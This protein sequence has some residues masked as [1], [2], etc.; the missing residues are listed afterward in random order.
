VGDAGGQTLRE[1]TLKFRLEPMERK[2]PDDTLPTLQRFMAQ[3]GIQ[4]CACTRTPE[5]YD[6]M[7]L[8][9]LLY[10]RPTVSLV[11]QL[12]L[13]TT[14]PCR[15]FHSLYAAGHHELVLAL[16]IH[17]WTTLSSPQSLCSQVLTLAELYMWSG[18]LGTLA[19]MQELEENR[20]LLDQDPEAYCLARQHRVAARGLEFLQAL[21]AAVVDVCS[22]CS[23]DILL[24]TLVYRLPCGHLFHADAT[25]CLGDASITT[26]LHMSTL[27]P[28]CKQIVH[29]VPPVG[30][31]SD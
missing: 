8:T 17:V 30:T 4:W 3:L 27:C 16:V 23:H 5:F 10:P 19:Q 14:P 29:I 11:A 26:W 24:E 9:Y 12:Y 7:A 18:Q 31:A 6:A 20:S 21:P 1:T 25:Q 13:A 28:N 22:I 15:C 2:E